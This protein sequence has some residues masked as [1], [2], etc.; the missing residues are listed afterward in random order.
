MQFSNIL[1]SKESENNNHF[2]Q[3]KLFKKLFSNEVIFF[4]FNTDE[5]KT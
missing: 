1:F 4:L 5:T 2:F 3:K